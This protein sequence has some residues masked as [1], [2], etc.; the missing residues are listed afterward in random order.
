MH[1]GVQ[2]A[3]VMPLLTVVKQRFPFNVDCHGDHS[4]SAPGAN[5][6]GVPRQSSHWSV[7]VVIAGRSWRVET[8]QKA[9]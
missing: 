8:I 3:R 5:F 9:E 1:I 2:H 7:D 4:I 6:G